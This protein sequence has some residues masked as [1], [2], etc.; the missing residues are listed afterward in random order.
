MV[1]E[2]VFS[3][4]KQ[5]PVMTLTVVLTMTAKNKAQAQL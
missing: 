2:K 4:K 5:T 1:K 3:L